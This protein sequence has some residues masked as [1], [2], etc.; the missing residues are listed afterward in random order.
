MILK[1]YRMLAGG[2]LKVLSFKGYAIQLA[3]GGIFV[4]QHK[5]N[6]FTRQLLE[7]LLFATQ[8]TFSVCVSTDPSQLVSNRKATSAYYVHS[9]SSLDPGSQTPKIQAVN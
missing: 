6:I 7:M 4:Q 9:V 2:K 5:N 3:D 1:I 8:N